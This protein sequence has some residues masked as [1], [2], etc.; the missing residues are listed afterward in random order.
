MENACSEKSDGEPCR[1]RRAQQSQHG[2]ATHDLEDGFQ[3]LRAS[4]ECGPVLYR[5]DMK[6]LPNMP[7]MWSL[8]VGDMTMSCQTSRWHR[9][10]QSIKDGLA[11]KTATRVQRHRRGSCANDLRKQS[12]P[13]EPEI[14]RSRA[15]DAGRER[16][17][18]IVMEGRARKQYLQSAQR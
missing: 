5:E 12:L 3:P 2:E 15:R 4:R 10:S 18:D 16:S 14:P 6:R 17:T 1:D 9:L 7:K 13:Q 8:D 11:T